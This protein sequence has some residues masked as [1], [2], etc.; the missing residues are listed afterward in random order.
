MTDREK[1]T[2]NKRNKCKNMSKIKIEIFSNKK[3]L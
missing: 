3:W 2:T 1:Q